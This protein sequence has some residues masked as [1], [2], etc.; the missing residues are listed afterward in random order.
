MKKMIFCF[1]LLFVINMVHASPATTVMCKKVAHRGALATCVSYGDNVSIILAC[2]KFTKNVDS[3]RLCY[4]LSE[5]LSP[6]EVS[7]CADKDLNVEIG[8]ME[9]EAR[10]FF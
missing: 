1:G 8:C 2:A 3:E 9:R 4:E 6:I 5:D 7:S 10:S